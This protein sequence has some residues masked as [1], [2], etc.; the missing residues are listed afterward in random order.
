MMGRMENKQR[1]SFKWVENFSVIAETESNSLHIVLMCM[2]S[3]WTHKRYANTYI[4]ALDWLGSYRGQPR[5]A[6]H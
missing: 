6:T 2:T 4:Y 3:K 5:N 1:D